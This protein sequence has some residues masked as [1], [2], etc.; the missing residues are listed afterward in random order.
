MNKFFFSFNYE[1]FYDIIHIYSFHVK[2]S[3]VNII[4][5]SHYMF[6][7]NCSEKWNTNIICSENVLKSLTFIFGQFRKHFFPSLDIFCTLA[8]SNKEFMKSLW[9]VKQKIEYVCKIYFVHVFA[10][11]SL[12]YFNFILKPLDSHTSTQSG[13]SMPKNFIT[14][15][16]FQK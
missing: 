5:I 9:Q 1:K 11:L 10:C 12:F 8:N 15:R 2:K 13:V 7:I 16:K 3:S 4:F 14:E 6:Y